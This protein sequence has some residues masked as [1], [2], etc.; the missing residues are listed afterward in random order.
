MQRSMPETYPS[1]LSAT[2]LLAFEKRGNRTL[3][4]DAN[5]NWQGRL[6]RFMAKV[7]APSLKFFRRF[8]N[9]GNIVRY[10]VGKMMWAEGKQIQ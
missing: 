8:G 3:A 6:A 1:S 5:R 9:L 10:L 7:L 4:V 2:T